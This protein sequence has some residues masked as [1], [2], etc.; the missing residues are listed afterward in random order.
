MKIEMKHPPNFERLVL[1]CMDSDDSESRRILQQFPDLQEKHSFASLRTQKF[2]IILLQ[3][4]LF[5][6][7]KTN[8]MNN[9]DENLTNFDEP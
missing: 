1:G 2:A 6:V 8:F 7:S 5:I 3:R 4:W 9:F